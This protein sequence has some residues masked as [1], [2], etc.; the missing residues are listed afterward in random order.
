M[1]LQFLDSQ[2]VVTLRV[3]WMLKVDDRRFFLLC[4]AVGPLHRDGNAVPDEGVLLLVDLHRGGGG[5]AALHLLLGL[6]HLC[7]G[8]P[9]IQPLEGLPKIP[10]QQNFAVACPAKGAVFAQ[11]FRVVGKGHLPAQ[12]SLQ[13]MPGALLDKD[14]FGVVVAHGITHISYFNL[15]SEYFCLINLPTP[16]NPG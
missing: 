14:I 15:L 16:S 6:V 8:E 3:I 12:F 11:L 7:G 1:D 2:E 9:R 10:G 5:E 13:Q 4:P